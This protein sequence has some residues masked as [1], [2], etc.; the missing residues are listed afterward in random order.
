MKLILLGF[1]VAI[2]IVTANPA[3]G[4]LKRDPTAMLLG[5]TSTG[6]DSSGGD[7]S[8]GGDTSGSDSSG[9]NPSDRDSKECKNIWNINRCRRVAGR[10]PWDLNKCGQ[11]WAAVNCAKSCG[12]CDEFIKCKDF[13][14][15]CAGILKKGGCNKKIP[16][17]ICAK[18]CGQCK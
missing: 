12:K 7:N 5:D 17:K 13:F 10:G 11:W 18:T 14:P 8:E 1:L 6:S 15:R 16:Q 2:A 4:S 9:S 3:A